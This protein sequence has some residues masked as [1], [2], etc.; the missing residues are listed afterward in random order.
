[1]L[2]YVPKVTV[3]VK[4]GPPCKCFL[5]LKLSSLGSVPPSPWALPSLIWQV[6]SMHMGSP[7]TFFLFKEASPP[8][9]GYNPSSFS[10]SCYSCSLLLWF[11]E[12]FCNFQLLWSIKKI[13]WRR[14]GVLLIVDSVLLFSI[15]IICHWMPKKQIVLLGDIYCIFEV[16]FMSFSS[17]YLKISCIF[18]FKVHK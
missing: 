11:W 16:D 1:M 9:L 17:L 3:E 13:I 18:L 7:L 14:L 12:Q 8:H 5:S 6:A 2:Y 4:R 10:I 15:A